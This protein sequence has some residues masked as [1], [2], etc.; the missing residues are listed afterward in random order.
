MEGGIQMSDSKT[1]TIYFHHM[2]IARDKKDADNT[3]YNVDA[4]CSAL[5]SLLDT[6]AKKDLPAK[7]L[8]IEKNEKIIWL[9]S[10]SDL[11]NG[12]F[13]L[14]FRSGKYNQSREVINTDTMEERGILQNPEDAPKEKTHLCIRLPK[15]A[16]RFTAVLEGNFNG[17][18]IKQIENYLNNQLNSIQEGLSD[19]YSYKVSFEQMLGEDFLTEIATMTKIN[20]MTITVDI[21]KLGS[22]FLSF[23]GQ[24]DIRSTITLNIHKEK[25][26]NKLFPKKVIDDAYLKHTNKQ[27]KKIAVQGNNNSGSLKIDT[28]SIYMKHSI[29]VGTVQPTNEL[30][31]TDFFDKANRFINEMGV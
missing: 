6:I 4:I 3:P 10:V 2:D 19:D 21:D 29:D 9:E 8:H 16:D 30:S 13:N 22:D 27:I 7:T 31:T 28:E 5:S 20:F 23:A 17:V 12:N 26:K 14:T 11:K 1:I 18:G 15:G 24:G 25:G